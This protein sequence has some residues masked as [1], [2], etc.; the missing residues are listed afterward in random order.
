MKHVGFDALT[1]GNGEFY[2]GLAVLRR[3][4][5]EAPFAILSSNVFVAGTDETLGRPYAIFQAGPARVAMFGLCTVTGGGKSLRVADATETARRLVP[6]LRQKA[7]CV[8]ALTHLGFL[9]D[10]R[11]GCAV[12]GIDAI[13]GG[14]SHTAL[15][16]GY[17][18]RSKSGRSV[19]ICQAGEHLRFLGELTLKLRHDG[20]RYQVVE[21]KARLWPL[22]S[23][24]RLD[25][26]T[27][28]L[29]AQLREA[30]TQPAAARPAATRPAAVRPGAMP[31]PSAGM[32]KG[33]I[34]IAFDVLCGPRS[35]K[36]TT[37]GEFP[38][39]HACRQR[40][41]GAR[42]R[43]H[44]ARPPAPSVERS[45]QRV[46]LA[47]GA[48]ACPRATWPISTATMLATTITADQKSMS[49]LHI[50]DQVSV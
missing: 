5:D 3:R 1:L 33:C 23:T 21:A 29:I 34:P 2:D 27:I 28:A 10:V 35:Y 18:V 31:A 14:H 12:D 13:V 32:P 30:T 7:D 41:R 6:V 42:N 17:Q 4:M 46:S 36:H 20:R 39:K 45:P 11:L 16:K 24:V 44:S 8:V 9:N 48:S 15:P 38:R 43:P 50:P 19:L 25:P 40:R 49:L 37:C 26:K 47:S 22:D